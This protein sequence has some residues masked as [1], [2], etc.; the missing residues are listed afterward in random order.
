MEENQQDKLYALT[1]K[2]I[3]FITIYYVLFLI[4]AIIGVAVTIYIE[5]ALDKQIEPILLAIVGCSFSGLLGSLMYYIRKIYLSS[6]LNKIKKSGDFTS[7]EK[8]GTI[9]YFVIRPI[10]SVIISAIAVMGLSAGVF[11]FF[12]SDGT[13]NNTFVDFTRVVSFFLGVSN[14][15]LIDRID[16]IGNSFIGKIFD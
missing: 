6:V 3:V 15:K 12:I 11:T 5:Y 7:V 4:V 14:G 2:N 8:W 9:I 13:L 1:Y 16:K 10:F